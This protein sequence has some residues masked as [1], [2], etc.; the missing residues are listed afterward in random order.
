M[1]PSRGVPLNAHSVVGSSAS[2]PKKKRGTNSSWM[3]SLLRIC[4]GPKSSRVAGSSRRRAPRPSRL[5]ATLA[6]ASASSSRVR[7]STMRSP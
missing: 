6:M 2:Q 7:P 4:A 5:A 3:S 1:A